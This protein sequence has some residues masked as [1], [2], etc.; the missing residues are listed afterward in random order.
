MSELWGVAKSTLTRWT[1]DCPSH[2]A[3]FHPP[4]LGI[5]CT[6]PF[7]S[8]AWKEANQADKCRKIDACLDDKKEDLSAMA[9]YFRF[10]KQ[11]V[12]NLIEQCR[13]LPDS[14]TGKSEVRL[15]RSTVASLT[16]VYQ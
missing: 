8:I 2:V 10:K 16:E 6:E 1:D 7:N 4:A 9:K 13:N 3:S 14:S 15:Y 5:T 11:H 12:N